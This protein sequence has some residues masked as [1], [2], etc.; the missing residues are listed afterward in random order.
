M[1]PNPTNKPAA[2][3][4]S[5]CSPFWEGKRILIAWTDKAHSV[6]SDWPSFVV[7]RETEDGLFLRGC[8][9]PDGTKHDGT[10]SF[11]KHDEI[12]DLWEWIPEANTKDQPRR[13]E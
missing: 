7:E 5:T 6:G 11:A 4:S 3:G 8:D 12:R 9:A 10:H 13:A 2:S 1:I